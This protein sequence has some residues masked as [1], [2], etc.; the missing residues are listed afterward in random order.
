M[1]TNLSNTTTEYKS[2]KTTECFSYSQNR[3]SNEPASVSSRRCIFRV[4]VVCP[5]RDS[6]S[7]AHD[8]HMTQCSVLFMHN[9]SPDIDTH[10]GVF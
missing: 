1:L 2:A 9:I 8:S 10:A 6:V 4:L 5:S 3:H 7:A